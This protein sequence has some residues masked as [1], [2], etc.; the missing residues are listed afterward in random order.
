MLLFERGAAVW[1]CNGDVISR[2]CCV[3]RNVVSIDGYEDVPANDERLLKKAVS[4]QPISVAIC[5]S[6][7]LQFYS[8][9]IVDECCTALDHGVLAV[10]YGV[11]AGIPFWIVKNRRAYSCTI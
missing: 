8:K 1:P 2:A 4:Q 6:E 7:N 9:G 3:R 10:G 5:A 11:Q